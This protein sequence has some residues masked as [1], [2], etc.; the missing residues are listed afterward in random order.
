MADRAV[1]LRDAEGTE[2][3]IVVSEGRV[4]AGEVEF[5]FEQIDSATS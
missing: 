1:S 4:T 2:Y 3:R 5:R